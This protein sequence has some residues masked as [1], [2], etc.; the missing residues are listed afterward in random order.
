M[1][2]I[3][4][5]KKFYEVYNEA[6]YPEI[7][8]KPGRPYVML[9]MQIDGLTFAIP[10]RSH[11]RHKFCYITDKRKCSGLDFS[12]AVIIIDKSYISDTKRVITITEK[13]N[14]IMLERKE[15]IIQRFKTYLNTYKRIIENKGYKGSKNYT[16]LQY[17]H[18]ELGLE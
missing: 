4:L 13:E 12:K 10:F 1:K 5:S 9:L 17:F 8:H 3:F 11:L 16:A 2:Y 7:L 18:K 15:V 14:K 6:E